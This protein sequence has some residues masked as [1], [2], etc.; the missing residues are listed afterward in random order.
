MKNQLYV[1]DIYKFP[2]AKDNID[3]HL[4]QVQVLLHMFVLVYVILSECKISSKKNL[5]LEE[6]TWIN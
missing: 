5:N 4:H 6:T 2:D 3:W 1:F